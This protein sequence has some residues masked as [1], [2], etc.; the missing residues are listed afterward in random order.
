MCKFH[1]NQQV[2]DSLHS[3]TTVVEVDI[4]DRNDNPPIFGQSFY[5]VGK[6]P[7]IPE[8]FAFHIVLD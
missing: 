6:M 8:E 4:I 5:E 1:V 3:A 2:S 7:A